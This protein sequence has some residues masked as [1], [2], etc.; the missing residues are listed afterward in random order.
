MESPSPKP[1]VFAIGEFIPVSKKTWNEIEITATDSILDCPSQVVPLMIKRAN[2]WPP[3][4]KDEKEEAEQQKKTA[5]STAATTSPGDDADAN[6][7]TGGTGTAAGGNKDEKSV[8]GGKEDKKEEKIDPAVQKANQMLTIQDYFKSSVG[9]F[10]MSIG[11]SRAKQIYHKDEIKQIQR[12]IRKEGEDPDLLEDLKREKE[13]Y[14]M[15]KK[16]N[17]IFEHELVKCPHCEFRTESA[18]VL[19][20]HLNFPHL[21]PKR[22]YKCNWC[23]YLTKD[24]KAI[25]FHNQTEHKRQCL[26]DPPPY[27]YECPYCHYETQVK[28]KAQN[29]I[30]KCVKFFN[31]DK[32]CAITDDADYPAITS[33]P[34][35]QEDIKIYEATLQ[36]LR[37]AALNPNQ[38]KVPQVPGIPAS[39]QQQLVMQQQQQQ[40]DLRMA[41]PGRPPKAPQITRIGG[42][43]V[44]SLG[45]NMF[46]TGSGKQA[47]IYQMLSSGGHTQ[48]V[49]FNTKNV[50]AALINQNQVLQQKNKMSSMINRLGGNSPGVGKPS[51]LSK[52]SNSVTDATKASDGG[53]GGT[54]VI[55]EICDGYIKDLEQLRTHMQWIHKVSYQASFLL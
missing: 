29:H 42:K 11:L 30:N 10:I 34:I 16:A 26:I 5:T 41:G 20:G 49:P 19:E 38:S 52:P 7:G 53:K 12:E 32:V 8:V 3:K 54:F 28:Q 18:I 40:N 51:I 39:L 48:L 6:S 43:P 44:Q 24:P 13:L 23:P 31:P 15:T 22:E 46:I 9:E 55:C 45:N 35:T 14:E 21:T 27:L 17:K 37:F 2:V 1:Q 36:A 50:S 25:V 33:K 4:L 47:Q